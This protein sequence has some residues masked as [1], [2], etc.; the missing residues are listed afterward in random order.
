MKNEAYLNNN[1]P[2]VQKSLAVKNT[3]EKTTYGTIKMSSLKSVYILAVISFLCGFPKLSVP[4]SPFAPPGK[5]KNKLML[6][7]LP[8]V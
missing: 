5:M 1:C 6:S 8:S 4:D 7:S 2:D 3:K